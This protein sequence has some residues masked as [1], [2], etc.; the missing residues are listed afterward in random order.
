MNQAVE[1]RDTQAC[2]ICGGEVQLTRVPGVDYLAV[3]GDGPVCHTDCFTTLMERGDTDN[4]QH[5]VFA[6]V[7]EAWATFRGRST[8]HD[9]AFSPPG[10]RCI[11]S[12]PNVVPHTRC[13]A[14]IKALR[15][16][17]CSSPWPW[18]C[19]EGNQPK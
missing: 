13:A 2:A 9:G 5:V 1:T 16:H 14:S 10:M 8:K 11:T 6:S 4:V 19:C 12:I 7:Y 17:V 3:E 15:R 18:I